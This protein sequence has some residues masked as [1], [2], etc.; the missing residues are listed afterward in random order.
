MLS[1]H[2]KIS[3]WATKF[4]SRV[5]Q[6]VRR[7]NGSQPVLKIT[8]NP[9]SHERAKWLSERLI[10]VNACASRAQA[11]MYS[12]QSGG[13]HRTDLQSALHQFNAERLAISI[14]LLALK[15]LGISNA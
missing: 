14:E 4:G 3:T 10:V 11:Q 5:G 9:I 15:D 12:I 1:L 8:M 6:I 13:A 2:T 7:Q